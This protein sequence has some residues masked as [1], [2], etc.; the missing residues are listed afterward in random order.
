[1]SK[2]SAFGHYC[3]CLSV[4]INKS[5]FSVTVMGVVCLFGL[6]LQGSKHGEM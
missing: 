5:L 1:M 6:G 4:F 2:Y 3:S